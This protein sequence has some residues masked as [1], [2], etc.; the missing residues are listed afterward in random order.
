MSARTTSP[1]YDTYCKIKRKAKAYEQS[2]IKWVEKEE[3]TALT[4]HQKNR[5]GEKSK[6]IMRVRGNMV[7]AEAEEQSFCAYLWNK[8]EK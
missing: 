5:R 2:N 4:Q 1:T 7:T 3:K 6:I 8:N